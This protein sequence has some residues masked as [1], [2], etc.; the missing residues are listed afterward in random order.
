MKAHGA[1]LSLNDNHYR[2][3][4]TSDQTSSGYRN[5]F[6][7]GAPDELYKGSVDEENEQ[8]RARNREMFAWLAER[9]GRTYWPDGS[10]ENCRIPAG[11]TYFAQFV[12]HDSVNSL[13]DLRD[14]NAE[15]EWLR[16]DRSGRL[17]LDTIY[18]KGFIVA[19]FLF[20]EYWRTHPFIEGDA[21]TEAALGRLF[22]SG[23]PASTPALIDEIARRK[24]WDKGD[25][26]FW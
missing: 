21:E 26:T 22:V 25:A 9:L 18:G 1:Q 23:P 11:Y 10:S 3:F 12:I 24:G 16:N 4:C 8:D 15:T 6:G 17:V 13:A 19:D 5:L 20:G 2:Q 14:L 7:H